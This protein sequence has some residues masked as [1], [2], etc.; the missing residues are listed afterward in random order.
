LAAHVLVGLA[1]AD[2]VADLSALLAELAVVVA[3]DGAQEGRL[4]VSDASARSAI[5][6]MVRRVLL[7]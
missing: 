3:V 1:D 4:F 5:M 6:S 7:I 2:G